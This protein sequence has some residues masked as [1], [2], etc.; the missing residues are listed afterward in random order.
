MNDYIII[1]KFQVQHALK[2]A[3]QWQFVTGMTNANADNYESKKQKAFYSILQYI[4]QKFMPMVMSF[5]DPRQMWNTLCQFFQRKM[6]SNKVCTLMQ[7]YGV[8]IKKGIRISEHLCKIDKLSDQLEAIREGV[9]EVHKVAVLLQSVQ[10]THPTLALLARDDELTLVFVKQ[11]L[12]DEEQRRAKLSDLPVSSEDLALRAGRGR[13]RVSGSIT[14]FNCGRK[15]HFA[16]GCL[17]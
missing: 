12:L 5:R 15:G 17:K 16:H 7:L 4:G 13:T 14:C 6:V 9:S 3:D 10:E 2:A 8:H 11:A 1:W